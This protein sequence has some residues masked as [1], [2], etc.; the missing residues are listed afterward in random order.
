MKDIFI[1]GIIV[2]LLLGAI[3]AGAY[4]I[5]GKEKADVEDLEEVVDNSDNVINPPQTNVV[6]SPVN[7][8][9]TT[10]TQPSSSS[11]RW[12]AVFGSGSRRSGS[13]SSSSSSTSSTSGTS[14]TGSSQNNQISSPPA[15]P[16][17]GFNTP[18]PPA[19][20]Q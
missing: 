4:F 19:L 15:L 16:E 2:I 5:L 14:N 6:P 13:S 10:N 9:V 17:S 8:Q 1:I 12:S 11:S 20:P 7:R 18:V 3:G